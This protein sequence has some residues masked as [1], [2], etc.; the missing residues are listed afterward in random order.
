MRGG[1]ENAT[2]DTEV[3]SSALDDLAKELNITIIAIHHANARGGI[4]GN[5][6]IPQTADVTIKVE[7]TEGKNS[8]S[9]IS[10]KMRNAEPLK[11]YTE[12]HFDG[13]DGPY[14]ME[15]AESPFDNKK[16]NESEQVVINY[17]KENGSMVREKFLDTAP[18][19]KTRTKW[20]NAINRL[21]RDEVID[22]LGEVKRNQTQLKLSGS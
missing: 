4:K 18:D 3:V 16:P 21:L 8:I 5:T 7:S 10:E 2:K 6:A 1:D 20:E 14:Y 17:L 19:E 9:F 22:H 11:I 13:I 12:I 15:E